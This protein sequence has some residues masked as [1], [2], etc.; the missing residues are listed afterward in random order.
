MKQ[1]RVVK[2]K[3]QTIKKSLETKHDRYIMFISRY[4]KTNIIDVEP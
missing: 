1:L 4:L 3:Y 2:L